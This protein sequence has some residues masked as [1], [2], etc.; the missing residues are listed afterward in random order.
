[1]LEGLKGKLWPAGFVFGALQKDELAFLA[2]Q[3]SPA[4]KQTQGMRRS[5]S[6]LQKGL[7][8]LISQA[9]GL[10]LSYV[11]KLNTTCIHVMH[12]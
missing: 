3:L 8:L 6:E 5:Y 9:A 10:H 1:M 12:I 11:G 2:S 4:W 7:V